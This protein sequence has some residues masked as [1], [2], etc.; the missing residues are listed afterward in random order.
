MEA[1]PA[2]AQAVVD[3]INGFNE[4]ERLAMRAAIMADPRLHRILPLCDM[5]YTDREGELWH[6][7]E[8]GNLAFT[9]QSRRRVRQGCVL[10]IF[11]FC[12]AMAPIYCDM[13]AKLGPDGML[14]A[15]SDDCC[16]HGPPVRVAETISAPPSPTTT[17]QNG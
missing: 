9:L 7:D 3:A 5:L 13:R 8:D 17:I 6:F 10:G 14:V 1:D 2:F 4:L 11:L 16:L 12:V 15:F